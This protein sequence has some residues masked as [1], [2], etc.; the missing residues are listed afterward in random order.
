M[1][2]VPDRPNGASGFLDVGRFEPLRVGGLHE[3]M[4]RRRA[5]QEQEEEDEPE[6]DRDEI[7]S[8]M[9]REPQQDERRAERIRDARGVGARVEVGHA[10]QPDATDHAERGA[11]RET[12]PDHDVA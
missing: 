10:Q 7:G 5:R 12:R 11:C 8:A 6:F 2:S 1:R 9:N 3:G 4:R